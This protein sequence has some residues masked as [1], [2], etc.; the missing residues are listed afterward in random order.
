MIYMDWIRPFPI[1]PRLPHLQAVGLVMLA[2][3]APLATALATATPDSGEIAAVFPPWWS[4]SNI[5]VA[6]SA[7]GEPVRFGGF[8]WILVVHDDRGN[9]ASRLRAAGAL[10]LL[11]S[12]GF[13]RC[14]HN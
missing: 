6:A 1:A 11:D 13:R 9:L 4:A 14:N 10:A 8:A 12:R 2:V 5:L 3:V 7:V